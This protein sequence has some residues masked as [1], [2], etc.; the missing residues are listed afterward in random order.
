MIGG[1]RWNAAWTLFWVTS[2]SVH[3]VTLRGADGK[4]SPGLED[5]GITRRQADDI[6]NEL[7]QIRLLL[8]NQQKAPKSAQ[9]APAMEPMTMKI[10][11]GPFLGSAD[12]PLTLVE[13]SD[14]QCPFCKQFHTA[15]FDQLRKEYIDKGKLRFI[16]R[17]LPLEMH[18][19]AGRAAQAAR[20]AGDQG[21]F[22]QMRDLLIANA[23]NLGPGALLDYAHS[24][25]L[26]AAKFSGC[27]ESGQHKSEVQKDAD[28]ANS[29]G[30]I[31]T[32]TFILGRTTADGVDGIKFLG[33]LPYPAFES[34][35]KELLVT[36]TAS[37]NLPEAH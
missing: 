17:D 19:S 5:A 12:A 25:S 26:D 2:L 9:G 32:P 18:S 6:L 1:F 10:D 20:C 24:L 21:R 22:W 23:G 36:N 14:Y 15:T 28:L 34:K 29:L 3:A 11:A 35:V 27:L 7:R 31:A 30:I 16:S 13:F 4:E 8:E 37:R 33:A